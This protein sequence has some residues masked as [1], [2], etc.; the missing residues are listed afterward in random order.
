[1]KGRENTQRHL[2][3]VCDLLH[4]ALAIDLKHRARHA[5]AESL[6]STRPPH[7]RCEPYERLGAARA[8][9]KKVLRPNAID[10][11]LQGDGGLVD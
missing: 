11:D 3:W 10:E 9:Q 6:F 4:V 7:P 8:C 2:E 5:K 1:M